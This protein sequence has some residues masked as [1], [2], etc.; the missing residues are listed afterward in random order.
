MRTNIYVDGFNL[1]YG[2]L[3]QTAHRWLDVRA[4]AQALLPKHQIQRVRYFTAKVSTI[5]GD[6]DGRQP[7]RQHMYIRAL[8][9][10]SD[11]SVHYGH[12]LTHPKMMPLAHP[13][14]GAGKFVEVI[15]TEEKGS[16]VNLATLLLLDACQGDFEQVSGG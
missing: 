15:K 13:L 7:V 11:V 16:D 3:K 10:S 5:P 4:L 6:G 1:Y 9:A 2:C 14:P 8:Q 12:Y